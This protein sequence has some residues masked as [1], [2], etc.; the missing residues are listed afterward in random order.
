MVGLLSLEICC[1]RPKMRNSVLEGLRDR[2]L[3]DIQLDT[4]VIV[5]AIRLPRIASW[6]CYSLKTREQA[7]LSETLMTLCQWFSLLKA[8]VLRCDIAVLE[9]ELETFDRKASQPLATPQRRNMQSSTTCCLNCILLQLNEQTL[10]STPH[11]Y[12]IRHWYI[13]SRYATERYPERCLLRQSEV[14]CEGH[15]THRRNCTRRVLTR[16]GKGEGRTL[17]LTG[18]CFMLF[19]IYFIIALYTLKK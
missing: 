17:N 9:I 13:E 10:L 3:D 18:Q 14:W 8:D 11:R 15:V 12:W 5:Y 19:A 2:K 16:A 1:G 7:E 6:V 4:L